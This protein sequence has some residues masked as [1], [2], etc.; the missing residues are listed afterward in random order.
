MKSPEETHFIHELANSVGLIHGFSSLLL[1]QLESGTLSEKSLQ[2]KL[3][4]IK[5]AAEDITRLIKEK[6]ETP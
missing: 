4:K 3:V 1:K 6:K 5:T 2:D